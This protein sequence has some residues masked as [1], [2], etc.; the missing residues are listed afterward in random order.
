MR[1]GLVKTDILDSL[2]FLSL[3]AYVVSLAYGSDITRG[4]AHHFTQGLLKELIE[5]PYGRTIF[6]LFS[7]G[8]VGIIH[9]KNL[10]TFCQFEK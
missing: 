3:F 7:R 2:S 1:R 10:L 9:I 8:Q 5:H 6:F 4:K